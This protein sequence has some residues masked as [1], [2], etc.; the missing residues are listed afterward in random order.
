MTSHGM[1]PPH[2]DTDHPKLAMFSFRKLSKKGKLEESGYYGGIMK[3]IDVTMFYKYHL[4]GSG[5]A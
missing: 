4:G 3:V 5:Y 2:V 1:V